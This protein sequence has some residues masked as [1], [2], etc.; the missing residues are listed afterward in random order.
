MNIKRAK[1]EIIDAV[2]AYLSKDEYGDW[3]I[4]RVR[5]RPILLLG[6]PGIGKTQIMEQAARECGVA[7]VAYSITHHTRQSAIG[8]PFI[9]KKQY[10][11]QEYSVTEYT[12]SEIVASVY[13]KM[14]ETGLSEGIL[15]ID[16]I[17]CVS[18]TLAPAMLQFLQCKTFGNHAIPEGWVIVA[19]GN[20]PE[21]NKSVRDF[22][23]VTLD[24]VKKIPVEPNLDVWK[25]YAYKEGIHPAILS[26]LNLRNSYFYKMET[27]V[28]GRKFAT[29]RGWEDLSR[30]IQVYEQL[31]KTVDADLILQYIQHPKIARDF[32]SYYDLYQKYQA[33]YQVEAIL[34]GDSFDRMLAKVAHASFDERMSVVHLLLSGVR[35][36]IRRAMEQEAVTEKVF[37]VLKDLKMNL[38]ETEETAA[39]LER[40][41]S[42]LETE[43][44]KKKKQELL[45]HREDVIYKESIRILGS[46]QEELRLKGALKGEEGF[47]TLKALFAREKEAYEAFFT[48][49]GETLEHAF[50]FFEAAFLNSQELV[51]FLSELNTDWNSIEFLKEYDCERYYRYNKEL[52]FEDRSARIK[53]RIEAL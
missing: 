37:E 14:E 4:P 40:F 48:E 47:D 18:E 42:L 44:E 15:F 36:A 31:K 11:G 21:Y 53:K 43:R 13:D 46:Y 17:N 6:A 22:D 32:A 27:T 1:Q 34:R 49:A 20:P 35:K 26:Y 23:V 50:D 5:Q 41:T 51:V 29:P 24:R 52:L 25:E 12:M 7:L 45:D 3:L 28:E 8:L 33:D 39:A 10:G 16:E 19:A 30:I 9:S 2:E 38:D